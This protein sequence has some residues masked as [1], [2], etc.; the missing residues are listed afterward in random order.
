[1]AMND[2]QAPTAGA[3]TRSIR[4]ARNE[5]LPRLAD[6]EDAA[7]QLFRGTAMEF[8][9]DLP[10]H[11]PP[12]ALPAQALI[13]VSVDANDTPQGFLEA[14]VIEGWLHILEL[15]VHPAAQRQGR[16][17]ALLEHA[18]SE[19]RRRR[20]THLSLTTDR[21]IPFNG[22]MYQRF[23]FVPLGKPDCPAW[24]KAILDEE[25]RHGFDPDR[26]V[27]MVMTP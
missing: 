16:A 8:V 23:G 19:A 6:I 20:L 9:L 7:E 3:H 10:H 1:M 17:R 13:W 24:L 26:R 27:A 18:R 21:A 15:S 22:P 25:V 11:P 2:G 4:A 14:E 5:D 12:A